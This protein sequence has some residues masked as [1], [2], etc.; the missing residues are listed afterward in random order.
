M[1]G[2]VRRGSIKRVASAVGESSIVTLSVHGYLEDASERA[3]RH[4]PESPGIGY[5]ETEEKEVY[6]SGS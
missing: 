1:V 2:G 3:G 4:Q 6:S 5:A